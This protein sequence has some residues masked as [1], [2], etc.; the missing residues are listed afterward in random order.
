MKSE[1]IMQCN[2]IF[3]GHETIEEIVAGIEAL[4]NQ[5]NISYKMVGVKI[6]ENGKEVTAR[7]EFA[8]DLFNN[9]N[10]PED[11]KQIVEEH[12]NFLHADYSNPVAKAA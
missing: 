8:S 3:A 1:F 6:V 11:M 2:M 10:K 7:D 9:W 5:Y 4:M 12:L